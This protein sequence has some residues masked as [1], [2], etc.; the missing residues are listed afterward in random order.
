MLTRSPSAPEVLAIWERGRRLHPLDQALMLLSVAAPDVPSGS[1]ADLSI[2]RRDD[3]LLT[4]RAW[5][6]GPRLQS[7]ADCPSCGERLELDFDVD[8]IRA[9]QADA[10]DVHPT[11][12]LRAAVDEDGWS[13]LVAHAVTIRYRLPNSRDQAF[14]ARGASDGPAER[15]LLARCVLE[16]R[17]GEDVLAADALPDAV[18]ETLAE[19]MEAADP[20]AD[21]RLDLTCPQCAIRWQAP[22]DIVTYLGREINSWA[23]RIL[24]DVHVLARAYGWRETDILA[25]SPDRRQFYLQMVQG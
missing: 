13:T 8:D 1:L 22:F 5:L 3:L 7:M 11:G 9:A 15:T 21:V 23:H 4:L 19:A 2:G 17:Q 18:V 6:F 20:Q 16:A 14:M 12:S 25:L 10:G 24:G